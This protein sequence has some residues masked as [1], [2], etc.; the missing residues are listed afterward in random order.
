MGSR[1]GAWWERIEGPTWVLAALIYAAWIALTLWHARVAWWLLIP[2]GAVV[3]A[4]HASLQ[5]ETIHALARVPRRLRTV[6]AGLPLGLGF[7]YALYHREH[8]KH[9][10]NEALTHPADDPET[11]YHSAAQWRSYHPVLRGVLL[12]NQTLLGRMTIGAP[13]RLWNLAA[14]ELRRVRAGDRSNLRDWAWHAVLV[15]LV[16]AW[17]CGVA[18][19]P[20]WQYVALIALPG[21]SLGMLRSFIEHRAA[22][23]A[24]HRTAI[25]ENDLPFGVLFLYNNL[26]AVHHAAPTLPWY[27]IRSVWR[28]QR[29][30]ILARNG[31]FHLSGYRAIAR[32]WLLSPVFRPI[33]ETRSP[34]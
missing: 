25:V 23:D 31:N 7:P 34:R 10:R 27:K 8:R 12:A 28:S 29:A 5:H 15:A 33:H 2:A 26:H 6:L 32:R 30:E 13:L 14:S 9:H 24:G 1:L 20:A 19:M 17:V 11:F 22:D 18:H 16:F 21:M 3:T 4:W